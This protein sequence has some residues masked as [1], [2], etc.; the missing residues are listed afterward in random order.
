[1]YMDQ[2]DSLQMGCIVLCYV[3]LSFD[4]CVTCTY[5]VYIQSI[6]IKVLV[7]SDETSLGWLEALM[8]LSQAYL[9]FSK[10]TCTPL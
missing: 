8:N 9:M 3:M 4:R 2:V 10:Y 1:M 6:H 7:C 5:T